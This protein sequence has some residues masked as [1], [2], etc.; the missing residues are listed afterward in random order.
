MSYHLST[1]RAAE[2]AD[3]AL[4]Y[5]REN[6][7]PATPENFT[8]WFEYAAGANPPLVKMLDKLLAS[9]QKI[10][11]NISREIYL[12]HGS[13]AGQAAPVSNQTQTV[14]E[15]MLDA[16]KQVGKDT[17]QYE[18]RL[19][20]FSGTLGDADGAEEFENLVSDILT[21][22][23]T[24]AN[25]TALLQ[26][27]LSDSSSEITKLRD[28]LAFARHD[29]MTDGLTGLANR[30]C[31]DQKLEQA[32]ESAVETNTPL[33]LIMADLDHFK[34]FNDKFGHTVGDQVLRI[35]GNA[36]TLRVKGEDTAARYGGEE[37][38]IILPMTSIGGAAALADDIRAT[39]ASK[40]LVK[41]G[42]KTDYG[43]ITMSLGATCY[44]PGE[45]LNEF[46]ER[47]DGAL[48]E[49]KEFGRN[50]VM[51]VDAPRPQ[52]VAKA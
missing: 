47:A 46:I 50:R 23:K 35:V 18:A 41:K 31:F 33:A 7:V 32:V 2:I 20:I 28:E 30:K 3:S 21:E 45:P 14:A 1:E 40:K 6:D 16:L 37:F 4:S 8:I 44:L 12:K 27:K 49:A 15:Q 43:I 24:M 36:L 29:A 52:A 13:D 39:I 10:D 25:H 42:G 17:E 34:V 22:T 5:M 26:D 9:N 48:Y 19:K 38:A 11:E 51:A